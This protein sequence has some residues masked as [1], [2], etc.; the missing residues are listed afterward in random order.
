M[1][2]ILGVVGGSSAPTLAR[3]ALRALGHRGPDGEGCESR[4]VGGVDV[5]LGHTRLAILDLSP[6]GHQP[7]ASR[8]GRWLLTFNGEIYNHGDIRAE[9]DGP[10]RSHSDTETL[11]EAI[12]KWGV[13][14]TVERLNGMF[15]FAA[16]DTVHKRLYLV[17]DPFGIKP[18]YYSAGAGRIA[19]A[20]EVRALTVLT[21]TPA[22]VCP[23]GLRAFLTLRYVPSPGTLYAGI[24]RV[25]P[26]QIIT[27]SLNPPAIEAKDRYIRPTTDRYSGTVDEAVEAYWHHLVKAVDRQLLADVP[28]GMLLSGG[29]DSAMVAVAAREAGR[30]LPC[31]TVGFGPAFKACEIQ[32]AAG[33]AAHLGL[34]HHVVEVG[35]EQ[36]WD[37]ANRAAESIEEPL[38]TVS[39]L[40][41]WHLVHLARRDATVVLA[42]QGTD[43]P[44]GG[45]FR[46]QAEIV[47]A[48]L[49]F[50]WPYR[51]AGAVAAAIPRKPDWAERALRSLR[52]D[53]ATSRVLEMQALFS[54]RERH[55]LVGDDNDGGAA[56]AIGGWLGWVAGRTCLTA[57][58]AQMRMDT[59]MNLADDLL[60]YGDK[61]SMAVGLEMRVPMLDLE[62]VRFEESL[63]IHY[64]VR[65]GRAKIVHRM[66]A[67]RFLPPEI[68]GRPKL[69]FAIPFAEF[70]RSS[71]RERIDGLLTG[72]GSPLAAHLDLDAVTG[73][74][75]AFVSG[76]GGSTRQIFSLIMLALCLHAHE[77]GRPDQA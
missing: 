22:R 69:G 59:R 40:P 17:R 73:L 7:M 54:A 30:A 55:A 4:T 70:A 43:E 20:S 10:F 14:R 1:C 48:Q 58:E 38:G 50:S 41:M 12:A 46:Y 64:R 33:T 61:L 9:L 67:N 35:P 11:A 24:S 63:P 5:L 25:E 56:R 51:V 27:I 28:V 77:G 57:V 45:Y 76:R 3:S 31:F 32:A 74:W 71:W 60:L 16:L 42:G 65:L 19:F 49:P 6:A 23:E 2:G 18:L 26:G 53:D 68:T 15:A 36:L 52:W 29:I 66:A 21:G 37:T 39:V 72:S 47:R 62:L 8:D 13:T 34:P 44:W 75:Q